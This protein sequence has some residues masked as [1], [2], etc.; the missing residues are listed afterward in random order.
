MKPALLWFRQF[1]PW[2]RYKNSKQILANWIQHHIK[3]IIHNDQMGFIWAYKDGSISVNL[4]C[5]SLF[6]G[7]YFTCSLKIMSY[8][9]NDNC[10]R[11]FSLSWVFS[12]FQISETWFILYFRGVLKLKNHF[13]LVNSDPKI[14]RFHKYHLVRALAKDTSCQQVLNLFPP[15]R[16]GDLVKLNF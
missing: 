7:A 16:Q 10:V 9:K 3:W 6:D 15:T 5:N 8:Y 4:L 1:S 11:L 13:V 2:C 14:G 12:I